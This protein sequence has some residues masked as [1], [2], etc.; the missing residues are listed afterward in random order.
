MS[1]Q[2]VFNKYAGQYDQSRKKLIPCFDDYYQT[3][4]EVIPFGQDSA[5]EVLDLGAGTGLVAGL[6]ADNY[7]GARI[8]LVDIAGEMLAKARNALAGYD[9]NFEFVTADYVAG[10]SFGPVERG[11][12]LIISSLS[13]HHLEDETKSNLF[14]KI[15]ANLKPGGVFVNADQALGETEAI[16]KVNHNKWLEQARALGATEQELAASLERMREDRMAPLDDQ[17]QWLREA[18]FA[19]VTC[20]YKNYSF[21]VYS[22]MKR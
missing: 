8:T 10:E 7:P 17:L 3:M 13:I 12:D 15:F 5:L 2:S 18:G 19:E 14:R 16:E 22:G 4:L 11:F 1:V 20:W 9:N 21:I 6:V